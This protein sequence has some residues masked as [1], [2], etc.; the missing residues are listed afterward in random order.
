MKRIYLHPLPVRIWHWIH[1]ICI[2]LL[3]L[4]GIQIRFADYFLLVPLKKA[5]EFHNI[6]GIIVS[7][8]FLLW[9]VYYTFTGKIKIYFP[10]AEELFYSAIR[11]IRYY[12]YGIF[13]GEPIPSIQPQKTNLI[14]CK[15]LLILP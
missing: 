14:H 5:V 1:A 11:Q 10:A 9:F 6:V 13:K 8:D 12:S 2:V 7:L 4:S 15:K 3:V